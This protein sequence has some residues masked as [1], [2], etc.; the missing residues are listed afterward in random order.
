M[1]EVAPEG[2]HPTTKKHLVN[3]PPDHSHSVDKY[4]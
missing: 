3:D 4:I 1:R 2:R